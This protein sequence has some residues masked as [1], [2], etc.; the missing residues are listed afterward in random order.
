MIVGGQK[1][2]PVRTVVDDLLEHHSSTLFPAL[3]KHAAGA[4]GGSLPLETIENALKGNQFLADSSDVPTAADVCIAVDL[5]AY[6]DTKLLSTSVSSFVRVRQSLGVLQ[7][8]PIC[9]VH[10]SLHSCLCEAAQLYRV[11]MTILYGLNHRIG[12][13]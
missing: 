12:A 2:G 4:S 11:T 13:V 9:A 1:V 5:L 10:F 6:A 7:L 3:L 8:T